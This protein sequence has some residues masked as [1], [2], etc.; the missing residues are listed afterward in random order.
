MLSHD[1]TGLWWVPQE[2]GWG[3]TLTQ[4]GDTVVAVIFTYDDLRR[5]AWYFA[6]MRDTGFRYDPNVGPVYGGT[7]YQTSGPWFGAGAFD[8]RSVTSTQVGGASFYHAGK[9]VVFG[10]TVNGVAVS[11]TLEQQ[12]FATNV[13]VL[14]G[15]YSGAF[16][17]PALPSS[18]ACSPASDLFRPPTTLTVTDTFRAG[19]LAMIWGTGI[20]TACVI[21]GPYVQTGRLG[22]LDGFLSCQPITFPLSTGTRIRLSDIAATDNGFNASVFISN[23][24]CAYS[25]RLGGVRLTPQ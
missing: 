22:S 10:Y 19:E 7:L 21:H 4:Q 25:G 17:F 14:N 8:P 15:S 12:T 20:D 24:S 13:P 1:V 18:T 5:P 6:A 16:T 2:S 11:K 9:Y 3:L 23:G